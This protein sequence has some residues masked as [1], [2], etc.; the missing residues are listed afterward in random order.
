MDEDDSDWEAP[1]GE[2]ADSEDEGLAGGRPQKKARGGKSPGKGKSPGLSARGAGPGKGKVSAKELREQL[3]DTVNGP[4]ALEA[5]ARAV[6]R[7]PPDDEARAGWE[8]HEGGCDGRRPRHALARR[9][10]AGAVHASGERLARLA[11]DGRGAGAAARGAEG[12]PVRP[13]RL[14]ERPHLRHQV[15]WRDPD[16]AAAAT[17]MVCVETHR[18]FFC[19]AVE[20]WTASTA[21]RRRPSSSPTAAA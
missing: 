9:S 4:A 17:C 15:R 7:L 3:T 19:P 5:T 20:S 2:G 11:A 12:G 1:G 10:P 14:P 21:I 16:I 18:R 8:G 6:A 13:P